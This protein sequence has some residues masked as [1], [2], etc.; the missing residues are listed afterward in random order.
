MGTKPENSRYEARRR[1]EGWVR[2]PRITHDA[3]EQL[4]ILAYRHRLTPSEVVTRLLLSVPLGADV[5]A[6]PL[7]MAECEHR[8]RAEFQRQHGFSDS[9]MRDIERM[10]G[11]KW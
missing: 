10:E 2:G 1:I 5:P 4:R 6:T 11:R 7:A 8:R 9:E 3:S